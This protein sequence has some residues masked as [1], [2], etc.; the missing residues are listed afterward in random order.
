MIPLLLSQLFALF[1]HVLVSFSSR[2]SHRVE[3]EVPSVVANSVAHAGVTPFLPFLTP[4]GPF[5]LLSGSILA[6]KLL[7]HNAGS[8]CP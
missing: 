8:L 1:S 7:A 3:D 5:P 4:L 6:N 2:K